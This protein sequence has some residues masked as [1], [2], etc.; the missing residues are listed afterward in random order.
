MLS[1]ITETIHIG[2]IQDARKNFQDF[3]FILNVSDYTLRKYGDIHT[4]VVLVEMPFEDS[5]EIDL[6]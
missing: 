6:G 1:K 4:S 5:P 3:D 2:N